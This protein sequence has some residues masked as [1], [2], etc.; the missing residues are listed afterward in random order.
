MTDSTD[1]ALIEARGLVAGYRGRPVLGPLD[2]ALGSTGTLALVGPNGV[3]KSTLLKT[4]CGVLPPLS[5]EL[6]FAAKPVAASAVYVHAR[7]GLVLVGE[8]RANVLRSL[9]VTENLA[10]ASAHHRRGDFDA[11]T[12]FPRLGERRRQ[13]AGTLSGGELQMLALAMALALEPRCLLL[14]EPSAGLAPIVLADV[15]STLNEL[16]RRRLCMIVAEQRPDVVRGLCDRVAIVG[17]GTLGYLDPD[18]DLSGEALGAAY[19]STDHTTG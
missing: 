8:H 7:R 18:T 5:G 6:T 14:D 9:T 19:F 15:H 17:G 3:G 2:L 16:R 10:L 13:Q 4:L 1:S 12:V 11:F